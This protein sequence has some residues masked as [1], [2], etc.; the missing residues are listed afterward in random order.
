M[1]YREAIRLG[2]AE[3]GSA[4][5]VLRARANV[6][7]ARA[8][9]TE[10]LV[11]AHPMV[12]VDEGRRA[13]EDGK[14]LGNRTFLQ[15]VLPNLA[16]ALLLTGQWDD[17]DALYADAGSYGL[18][19]DPFMA[20]VMVA[21]NSYRGDRERV[22]ALGELIAPLADYEDPQS[23]SWSATFTA[24]LNEAEGDPAKAL[25]RAKEALGYVDVVGLNTE[26]MR[27][28][29]PLAV[30]AAIRLEDQ[31]GKMALLDWLQV[32]P[33]GRLSG[34]TNALGQR[35]EAH[36]LSDRED[37][38]AGEV[39]HSATL[40]V[41]NLKNPYHLAICLLDE[42]Q[43]LL[44]RGDM[45]T[46]ADLVR[47]AS[48]IGQ[49]LGAAPLVNKGTALSASTIATAAALPAHASSTMH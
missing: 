12:A 15:V 35:L 38:S 45:L 1:Y 7:R 24:F 20:A 37:P 4:R 27:F 49:Q 3:S 22:L 42:A 36:A 6:L 44:A 47:E 13:A 19:G 48:N 23:R 40:A 5:G 29:W 25:A 17:V 30:D 16:Q 39:F 33:P 28:A 10:L 43:Y 11:S 14:R 46:G 9:L 32:Y 26:V 34:L 31:Q 41:R 18:A 21:L 2:G 8:N